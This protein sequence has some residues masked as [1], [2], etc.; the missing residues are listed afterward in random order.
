MRD[1]ADLDAV[2]LGLDENEA[3][4]A[5]EL[6]DFEFNTRSEA[7]ESNGGA[8]SDDSEPSISSVST[9]P[10]SSGKRKTTKTKAKVKE[11][12][13]KKSKR[14]ASPQEEELNGAKKKKQRESKTKKSLTT[15]TTATTTTS[16]ESTKSTPPA[17]FE[18]KKSRHK[19]SSTSTTTTTNPTESQRKSDISDAEDEKPPAPPAL[20]SDS[21]SSDS[22][23]GT[24]HKRNGGTGSGRGKTSSKSSTPEK[25]D[26]N[27]GGGGA[28]GGNSQKAYDY[29][30]KLNYLFRDTRFFLIKSNNS[31]NVQLSK[32]KNVWATL[33]QNDANL[34]QAFKEAR[35]VLLIFSVNESGKFA[36]F[37]RMAA[38]SRRDIPQVAWVLPPSISPKALGGVIE[39]DWICRKE[40]SFNATLHLHNSWN[41]G[42]PVKI[43]RDGQEIEPKIGGEL[44]RLFPEDEQ[45]ELTPILRKSK[46]TARVMREKGIHVIYKAPR[47]L[48]SRGH[49]V[50]GGGSQLGPMRHKRSYHG[51]GGG[52]GGGGGPPPHHHHR[53]YRHHHN[54]PPSG[55]FKRNGSPYRQMGG[56][57][58]GGGA[59]GDM[60]LPAW[61]RYMSS[62]AAAE[63]YV[64]DYMRNMHGQLPPLP[65][66][67]PFAQLPLPGA[68]AG[69]AA[70]AVPPGANASMYEQL[71]PPVRYY[72][73]PGPPPLPD[74]PPPQP[75]R[76]P[77]PGFDKAPSYEDFAAWKNAG[78]PTVPPPGFPSVY[79]A[80]ANG[81]SNGAAGV[82]VTAGVGGVS[83]GSSG[84]GDRSGGGPG[85][86]R[87]RDNNGSAG[88]RRRDYGGGG[89]RSGVGGG[90]SRDSRPFRGGQRS[91]RDT[92]R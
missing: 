53:P 49:G 21:E 28:S 65:F 54:Y 64:A 75:M 29:M 48:S 45:I 68:G 13:Q 63:A 60:N 86:Y 58:P 82:A 20:E 90:S 22:D 42:K 41:E 15:T 52:A 43:G 91:Y 19:K 25:D 3:D 11:L 38:P 79:G 92:R 87:S 67:P 80:A 27:Q 32:S 55:G 73:G 84:S 44:C 5:E 4:I 17:E 51:G 71:P 46:E 33:P 72:D 40:L 37:A 7:S 70:G 36:G 26:N 1:M 62:A 34:N 50:R 77:P 59:A 74:Y 66:V 47:S 57:A 18:A 10:S 30:T 88:S 12:P 31:D 83:G 69:G 14:E 23:S 24:Q 81:G 85:S 89:N 9:A 2:H 39:L 78:L 8:S 35:N 6:Q 56:A 61:E 16:N 76:P